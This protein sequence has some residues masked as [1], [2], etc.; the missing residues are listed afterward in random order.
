MV[1]PG[2]HQVPEGSG[3]QGKM[4][5]TGYEIVCGAQTTIAIKGIDDDDDVLVCLVV[6]QVGSFSYTPRAGISQV[7][8][9]VRIVS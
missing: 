5:E 2:V 7:V 9:Y 8:R 4:E 1:R 3:E 6:R